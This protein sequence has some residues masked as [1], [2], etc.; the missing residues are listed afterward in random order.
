MSTQNTYSMMMESGS[1]M[2]SSSSPSLN[3]GGHDRIV[4]FAL[5]VKRRSVTKT[6]SPGINL[7]RE[8]VGKAAG[9]ARSDQP[10]TA[11][12]GQKYIAENPE[13]MND[14]NEH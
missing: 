1:K 13:F 6:R 3:G 4:L 2:S 5:S 8:E 10:K 12:R 14:M 7:R 11:R 9:V